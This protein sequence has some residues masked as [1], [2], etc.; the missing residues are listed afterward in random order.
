[1]AFLYY[2]S[3]QNNKSTPI[4]PEHY[5][6]DS[7]LPQREIYPRLKTLSRLNPKAF[8]CVWLGLFVSHLRKDGLS[9]HG[10]NICL[11]QLLTVVR[12][13]WTYDVFSGIQNE[14]LGFHNWVYY[15]FLARQKR[16]AYKKY[17]NSRNVGRFGRKVSYVLQIGA[18]RKCHITYFIIIN[19]CPGRG[20]G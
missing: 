5:P 9:T 13:H 2:S 4:R 20:E 14:V 12:V 6:D 1:M 8:F 16:V 18:Q 19:P 7:P 10:S 15:S 11:S 17:F 3:S